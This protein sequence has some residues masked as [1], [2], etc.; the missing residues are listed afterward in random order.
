VTAIL[1]ILTSKD[2]AQVHMLFGK[3]KVKSKKQY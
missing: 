2:D 1:A 3:N